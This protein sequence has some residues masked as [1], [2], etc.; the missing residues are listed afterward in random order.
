MTGRQRGCP[1]RSK[2]ADKLGGDPETVGGG[3]MRGPGFGMN[4]RMIDGGN[5]SQHIWQQLGR[6]YRQGN[7][8][9]EKVHR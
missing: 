9:W 4:G 3:W 8:L 2:A 1:D 5:G 6:G 7:A